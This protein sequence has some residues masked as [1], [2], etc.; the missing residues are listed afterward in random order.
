MT[1]IGSIDDNA[2]YARRAREIFDA[3][4]DEWKVPECLQDYCALFGRHCA[5]QNL[6]GDDY[7]REEIMPSSGMARIRKWVLS[8]PDMLEH[9]FVVVEVT[10]RSIRMTY[11][12]SDQ[13]AAHALARIARMNQITEEEYGSFLKTCVNKALEGTRH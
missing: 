5:M 7:N 9:D 11:L 12:N 13:A 10:E 3:M 1:T 6:F 4:Y 8:H 2:A